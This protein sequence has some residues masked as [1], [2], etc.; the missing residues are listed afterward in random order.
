M[1]KLFTAALGTLM[2]FGLAA[3][4]GSK[5]DPE[6]TPEPSYDTAKHEA[7]AGSKVFAQGGALGWDL[8][9]EGTEMAA[10]TVADVAKLDKGVADKL[11]ANVSKLELLYIL[12]VKLEEKGEWT[13]NVKKDGEVYAVDGGL[14]IKGRTGEYDEADEAWVSRAWYPDPH[15]YHAESLTPENLFI[16]ENWAE[17]ADEDGFDWTSNPAAFVAGTYKFVLAVYDVAPTATAV[18]V[19]M[20]LIK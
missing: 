18:N 13:T 15:L 10:T 2:I 16:A 8:G 3:C 9:I 6:P 19:G 5:K 20:A 4:G 17:E 14:T 7:P 1:K 11:Q 12:E